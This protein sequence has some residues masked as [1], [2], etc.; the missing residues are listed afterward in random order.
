MKSFVAPRLRSPESSCS[1]TNIRNNQVVARFAIDVA[2]VSR[3]GSVIK[4][5]RASRDCSLKEI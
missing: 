4:V 2:F 1:L 5:S 3:H